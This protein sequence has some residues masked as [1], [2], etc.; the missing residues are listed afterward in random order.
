MSSGLYAHRPDEL[1]GIAVVPA[2]QRAAM[3]ETAEIWR[4]LIHELA[5]VRA[6]TAAA[7]GASDESARV[8]MLM[9]I[10]A[11]ADEVT[12]LVQQLKPDHHAA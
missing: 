11:E 10:E 4:E 2:A 3:R 7:L 1:D 5:T 8:A 12:A 6:L 9:L